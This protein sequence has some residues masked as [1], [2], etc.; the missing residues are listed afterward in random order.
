MVVLE[1]IRKICAL[2]ESQ[3][4]ITRAVPLQPNVVLSFADH[5]VSRVEALP[6]LQLT[7][8]LLSTLDLLRFIVVHYLNTV[9]TSTLK[10]QSSTSYP[11]NE[12]SQ[13]FLS[14][15]SVH[16]FFSYPQSTPNHTFLNTSSLAVPATERKKAI[17]DRI[18]V[19]FS[20][21]AECRLFDLNP[22]DPGDASPSHTHSQNY[23]PQQSSQSSR[24]VDPDVEKQLRDTIGIVHTAF[25]DLLSSSSRA[26]DEEKI[27]VAAQC[28]QHLGNE[29]HQIF[30]SRVQFYHEHHQSR[31]IHQQQTRYQQQRASAATSPPSAHSAPSSLR[32]DDRVY[33][34]VA[35]TPLFFRY[36]AACDLASPRLKSMVESCMGQLQSRV[37]DAVEGGDLRVRRK[38]LNRKVEELVRSFDTYAEIVAKVEANLRLLNT[39]DINVDGLVFDGEDSNYGTKRSN[40]NG[41]A[42]QKKIRRKKTRFFEGLSALTIFILPSKT[43]AKT[44]LPSYQVSQRSPYPKSVEEVIRSLLIESDPNAGDGDQPQPAWTEELIKTEMLTLIQ[45]V[46]KSGQKRLGQGSDD[47]EA[48]TLVW[49]TKDGITELSRQGAKPDKGTNS[50]GCAAVKINPTE[51]TNPLNHEHSQTSASTKEQNQLQK[52]IEDLKK[53]NA[54]LASEYEQLESAYGFGANME[55]LLNA[56]IKRLHDYNEIKDVGRQRPWMADEEILHDLHALCHAPNLPDTEKLR[57]ITSYVDARLSLH[58]QQSALVQ[59][60]RKERDD[61]LGA[62]GLQRTG[63]SD[64]DPATGATKQLLHWSSH[65]YAV[66]LRLC[67]SYLCWISNNSLGVCKLTSHTP[68]YLHGHTLPLVCLASNHRNLV[69]TGGEDGTMRLWNLDKLTCEHTFEVDILDVAVHETTCVSYNNDNVVNVWDLETKNFTISIDLRVMEEVDAAMLTREVKV[70]L[71]GKTIVCGFE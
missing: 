34:W 52:Q 11:D 5:L 48:P 24:K 57:L 56:H 68:T 30:K 46:S 15:A 18:Q 4:Q 43:A 65:G 1:D 42:P 44:M 45:K 33:W 53:K 38:E 70:A 32:V 27:G 25:A 47:D 69:V 51:N 20:R 17:I 8:N 7:Q 21:M 6:I 59:A 55:D 19:I 62:V 36:Q 14:S 3:L 10:T 26:T 64:M 60:F 54:K 31:C 12:R 2:A 13:P 28:I 23:H 40:T 61:V 29:L 16:T 37:L 49:L 39:L 66:N 35:T 22:S 71:W 9:N 50:S 67:G 63:L 58:M 41:A